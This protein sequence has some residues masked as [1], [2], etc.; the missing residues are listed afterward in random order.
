M[1]P[2]YMAQATTFSDYNS[3]SGLSAFAPGSISLSGNTIAWFNGTEGLL[4]NNTAGSGNVTIS[5]VAITNNNGWQGVNITTNG[6]TLISNLETQSN[7]LEGLWVDGY[8]Y[9]KGVTLNNILVQYN[10]SNGIYV[11]AIGKLTLNG[12]RSWFNDGSGAFLQSYHNPV[13]ISASSFM[14]NGEYGAEVIHGSGLFT[15]LGSIYLGNGDYN[16]YHY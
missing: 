3:L 16:L 8:G 11:D 14:S 4:L 13:S 15:N 7:G 9:L 1:A 12:V 2:V 6:I 10:G 5:G